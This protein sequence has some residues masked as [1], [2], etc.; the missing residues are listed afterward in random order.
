MAN[1]YERRHRSLKESQ[2]RGEN[3]FASP[4]SSLATATK[5]RHARRRRTSCKPW[6]GFDHLRPVGAGIGHGLRT[7][8]TNGFVNCDD[9]EY[10]YENLHIQGGLNLASADGPSPRPIRP[11]GIR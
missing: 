5:E 2:P 3:P 4:R 6:S 8:G 10:V 1:K 7:N 9:N 11:T